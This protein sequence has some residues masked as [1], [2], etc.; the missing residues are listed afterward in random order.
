MKQ[1][2]CYYRRETDCPDAVEPVSLITWILGILLY[3]NIMY[4][5]RLTF[6]GALN[7][8]IITP[9]STNPILSFYLFATGKSRLLFFM[10]SRLH[11]NL[12]I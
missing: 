9:A 4:K 6:F 3:D 7:L 8:L 10:N 12:T 1:I 2:V 11:F 5:E